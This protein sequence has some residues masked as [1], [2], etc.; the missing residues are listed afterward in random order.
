M[1]GCRLPICEWR[2]PAIGGR[3]FSLYQL[4]GRALPARRKTQIG[5]R[6]SEID[7]YKSAISQGKT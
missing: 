2:E 3:V 7:N 1:F 6:Q 5:N 4:Q